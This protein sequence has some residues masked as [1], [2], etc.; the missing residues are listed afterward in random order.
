MV[1]EKLSLKKTNLCFLLILCVLILPSAAAAGNFTNA[2]TWLDGTQ[3]EI[4]QYNSQPYILFDLSDTSQAVTLI[5]LDSITPGHIDFT[6]TMWSGDLHVGYIDYSRDLITASYEIDLD[7][8]TKSWSALDNFLSKA[9]ISTYATNQ[10]TDTDGILLYES[11]LTNLAELENYVFAPDPNI[12][13]FPIQKVEIISENPI[14]VTISYAETQYVSKNIAEG[15]GSLNYLSYVAQLQEFLW[16]IF[17]VLP[18]FLQSFYYLFITHFFEIIVLYELVIL[19]YAA[20]T[21]ANLIV[22]VKRVVDYNIKFITF[23]LDFTGKIITMLYHVIS[24][25][26]PWK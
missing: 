3:N 19:A 21:S 9:Y 13:T 11:W 18:T 15:V 25:I 7:G 4:A 16:N 1:K 23:W 26:I 10:D 6:L 22:W 2:D 5:T 12:S 24:A 20:S 14:S 8:N 17:G